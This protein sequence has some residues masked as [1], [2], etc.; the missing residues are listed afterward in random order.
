M[1]DF[2]TT[3]PS[4]GLVFVLG[5]RHGIDP[6][7]IAVIDNMTLRA[8]ETAARWSALTGTL[9]A[10][11]HSIAVAGVALAVAGISHALVWPSWVAGAIDWSVIAL[12]L[13]VGGL[14]LRALLRPA[15]Y[16]P[17][18]WRQHLIPARLRTSTSAGAVVAVGVIFGLV[19]DTATQA[20]AWGASASAEAGLAGAAAITLAFAAGMIVTDTLD[21]LVVARLLRRR[22]DR[23]T[24]AL[25][26]RGIGWLIVVLSFGMALYAL[27]RMLAP[28][29]ELSTEFGTAL[30]L[31]MIA[32]V[33]LV[34]R[35]RR[36]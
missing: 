31:A 4:L 22:A 7:H 14:N 5:L 13:L 11:G 23:T 1:A 6:D 21:S 24:L 15:I 30:G 32:A 29:I 20:A 25:Y 33:V 28:A 26:R 35:R 9:F 8:V 2:V 36:A 19:F 10:I 12:L 18:G 3:A 17:A 27:V 16:V 34:S